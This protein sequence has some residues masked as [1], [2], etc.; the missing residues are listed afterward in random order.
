[1]LKHFLSKKRIDKKRDD[2]RSKRAQKVGQTALAITAGAVFLNHS[3]YGKRLINAT[4]A[5]SPIAKN[6]KNDMIKNPSKARDLG[7]W[8]KTIRKHAGKNG[9][10]LKKAISNLEKTSSRSDFK[11][12]LDFDTTTLFKRVKEIYQGTDE[13]YRESK[14]LWGKNVAI[15]NV[16]SKFEKNSKFSHLSSEQIRALAEDVYGHVPSNLDTKD[17]S[18]IFTTIISPKTFQGLNISEKDQLDFIKETLDEKKSVKSY[19]PKKSNLRDLHKTI[20]DKAFEYESL[21]YLTESKYDKIDRFAYKYLGIK[22]DSEYLLTGSKSLRLKDL[23]AEDEELLKNANK[24]KTL[25]RRYDEDGK[26]KIKKSHL[27]HD[28]VVNDFKEMIKNDKRY[29]NLIVDEKIRYRINS[30]GTKEWF[31]TKETNDFFSKFFKGVK[32]T[33]P[34]SIIFRGVDDYDS[35][36]VK[37]IEAGKKSGTAHLQKITKEGLY[38][39]SEFK[40]NIT[41][42]VMVHIAGFTYDITEEAGRLELSTDRQAQK[43]VKGYKRK[44]LERLLGSSD[45][46]NVEAYQGI[47]S[48]ILD[49]NQDGSKNIFSSIRKAITRKDD[50]SWSINVLERSRNFLID[51]DIDSSN[52]I[53]N[54]VATT[55]TGNTEREVKQKIYSELKY[56]FNVLNNNAVGITDNIINELLDSPY[57]S[58]FDNSL[59]TKLLDNDL[60][61]FFEHINSSGKAEIKNKKLVEFLNRY[62][63]NS[64]EVINYEKRR[65]LAKRSPLQ[66]ILRDNKLDNEAITNIYGQLRVEVVKDIFQDIDTFSA[67]QNANNVINLIDGFSNISEAEKQVLKDINIVSMFEKD[68]GRNVNFLTGEVENTFNASTLGRFLDRIRESDEFKY[69]LD[70]SI[71]RVKKE[72]GLSSKAYNEINEMSYFTDFSDAMFVNRSSLGDIIGQ[73]LIEALNEGIK[74]NGESA[75]KTVK[76]IV[77]GRQDPDNI[78]ELTLNINY[79][80]NRLSYG[81]EDIGLGLSDKS[82]ANA[83]D[84]VKNIALKRLL[85]AFA[86]YSAFDV[87]DYE[88]EKITG[89]SITGVAANS[90]KN[91]DMSVR[92][93]LDTTHLTGAVNWI[94]ETSV[95]HEYLTGQRH[96]NTYEEQEDWYNNGY[97]PV[98]GGRFWTF[99]ST[100]EF[101]GNDIN[102][103]QPNFWK[104]AHSDYHDISVYGS[105]DE[106]WAHSWIPTPQ[107]PLSPIRRLLDPYWLE[108][109]HLR[110]NDRPYPITGKMFSEGTPWGAVLNPTVGEILKPVKMLPQA[111]RRLGKDGIDAQSIIEK[112]NTRIKQRGNENDDLLVVRGSDVR[113]A[114]YVPYGNPESDELNVTIDNGNVKAKG[115]NYM[116]TLQDFGEYE[117]PDG[118]SYYEDDYGKST[119]IAKQ[120]NN[121]FNET[122][123]NTPPAYLSEADKSA[124]SIIKSIND[125]IIRKGRKKYDNRNINN[126]NNGPNRQSEGVYVYKNLVNERLRFDEDYYASKDTKAMVNKSILVDYKKD[127]V[128]SA[129]QLSGIYGYLGNRFF[130]ENS[131]TYR[132]ENAGKMSSFTRGY[133]DASIGGLGGNFME[134][135]RRFFPSEDRSRIDINPLRNNMPDWIP[136]SYHQ[137][138]PYA[139]IP[140]GEMRLPGKGY[141]SLNALHPDEFGDYGAFDRYKILADIAPNS[142]E[143]KKWKKIAETTIQDANLKEQMEEIDARVSKMSGK[144]EFFE[145]KYF[146]N[147]TKYEKVIVTSILKDGKVKLGNGQIV[148]LAGIESN[149]NTQSAL[150][151]LLKA[152][153]K[154]TIRTYK[155][156]IYKHDERESIKEVVIYKDAENISEQL[157]Q[158][159]AAKENKSDN[160]ALSILGR[161]SGAQEMIGGAIELIAH[162]DIPMIHNKFL[163]VESALESYKNESF[164]GSNF[165]TWE[166]PIKNFIVPAFNKQ[167]GYGLIHESLSLGYAAFHFSKVSN[168][169]TNPKLH[170]ASSAMLSI[171]NPTAFVGG[172]TAAFFTGL[173]NKNVDKETKSLKTTWQL[174]AEIGTAIGAVKYGY[175]NADNPI[176][177]MASFAV[178]GSALSKN[179]SGLGGTLKHL[180]KKSGAIA[181]ALVGLGVSAIKN[182]DFDLDRM[183]NKKHVPEY[184]QK[185]W[186][187]DEYFDRL[188]YVKY[189]G[190]YKVASARAAI[191]EG[192]PVRDIFK[193]IDKN[194]KEIAKL[195]RKEKKLAENQRGDLSKNQLKIEEIRRKRMALEENTNMFFKGGKYTKAAVAYKKK[196]ESTIYGL[197]ETATLDEL[198]AAVPDQYKDHFNAFMKISDKKQQKE[199]LKYVPDY[200]A[201][202]LKIAWGEKPDRIQSNRS[203]FKGHKMPSMAWKGWKPNINMKHIKIK[204][205]ENEGMVMSDFGYY[206]SEK[207]KASFEMAPD[208][209]RYSQSNAITGRLNMMGAL[210]GLGINASNV[211]VEQTSNPG[212]WILSDITGSA[213]DVKK[214]A[215]YQALNAIN[216]VVNAIF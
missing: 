97:T 163:K 18:N 33:L 145:Y 81:L 47:L 74:I 43:L 5:I 95:I 186:E 173:V 127:V 192:T 156:L 138:D 115:Y 98:R 170:F 178:A 148:S 22:M 119:E 171:L 142:T 15:Q 167:S 203:Y 133:W 117:T 56:T 1:M 214:A 80:I 160:S 157:L 198:L 29:E 12:N 6:I 64:E 105:I 8:K 59:L 165:Q 27:T 90:L 122:L 104:R 71:K 28:E 209:E 34:G 134:I 199:I 174:G 62:K 135:A 205:I 169:I 149:E 129:K 158:M 4:E 123:Q 124:M 137:G 118:T 20:E 125:F 84:S 46:Y 38:E 191:F 26:A 77:A 36:A 10:E 201:K 208:I 79:M 60:E 24:E 19:L 103:F 13:I 102:Y 143:Y 206:D 83:L 67:T 182:P 66:G 32:E 25:I 210:H 144:H 89:T 30:D 188:S 190:L 106:K 3:D 152:G 48:K 194:K 92:R 63:V 14:R 172:N 187:L 109:K 75:I 184:T 161:Q 185:K 136:D 189:M 153:D 146:K 101:R 131:Y 2:T 9:S 73:N 96:F 147:N 86:L 193:E 176:K 39:E 180:D 70:S 155:D 216:G 211:T 154:V 114:E 113:N 204:T 207:S 11:M 196:A 23:L 16:V 200:L 17:V 82:S 69:D 21:R 58:D 168:K 45:I 175:D 55:V 107:H 87:L 72:Y 183:F 202:P 31:Q 197:D 166:H 50:D 76:E 7:T 41:K 49:I 94:A 159:G 35:I 54:I 150:Q 140:K 91:T 68:V 121:E 93:L 65:I 42:S 212:M 40:D 130:G 120:V 61:G 177:A 100:S 213:Y 53:D 215:S 52:L 181:G 164:Y 37:M 108:K 99:G 111:K 126:L 141:E 162:A 116:K 110:E 179:L 51:S 128:Y 112:I 139:Q 151:E 44:E 57:V 78:S 88:S 85:P 195:N 132:Y